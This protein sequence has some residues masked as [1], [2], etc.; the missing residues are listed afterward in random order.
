[1]TRMWFS[2]LMKDTQFARIV[3]SSFVHTNIVFKYMSI[4]T[5][6]FAKGSLS[7]RYCEKYDWEE[8]IAI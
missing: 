3:V 8:I 6:Y 4:T 5:V 1:M 7:R 2:L